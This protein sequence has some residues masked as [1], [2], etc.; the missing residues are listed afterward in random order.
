MKLFPLRYALFF[1]CLCTIAWSLIA[2]GGPTRSGTVSTGPTTN[3]GTTPVTSSSTTVA[4]SPTAVAANGVLHIAGVTVAVNPS[5][6]PSLACTA[7]TNVVFTAAIAADPGSKGGTAA[8]SWNVAGSNVASGNVTF[9]PGD[10]SKTVSY[11]LSNAALQYN[12]AANMTA[13]LT[14]SSPNPITSAPV[15]PAGTCTYMGPFQVVSIAATAN[16]SSLTGIACNSS[17]TV[18][19]TATVNIA[20]NSNGGTVNFDAVFGGAHRSASVTF[21][22]GTTVQVKSFTSNV[23]VTHTNLPPPVVFTSTSPNGMSSNTVRPT[24]VCH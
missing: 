4:T 21:S 7:T 1:L 22:P 14:V 18:T 24:G 8:F 2:C 17:I 13:T 6:L 15:K 3:D 19:Y 11:T 23:T 20:A 10:T 16:P 12:N 9:G 5:S